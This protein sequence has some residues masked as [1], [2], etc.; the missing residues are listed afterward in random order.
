MKKTLGEN[1]RFF[2]GNTPHGG[3]KHLDVLPNLSRKDSPQILGE[4]EGN[5]WAGRLPI[6]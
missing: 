1:T 4:N 5:G 2:S 6:P 3:Q